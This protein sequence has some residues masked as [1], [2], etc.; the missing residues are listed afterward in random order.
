MANKLGR[1]PKDPNGDPLVPMS[2]SVTS[3]LRASFKAAAK[4]RGL[5]YVD[6]LAALVASDIGR[7]ELGP[8][9]EEGFV[10][11]DSA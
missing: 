11:R 7:L 2:F 9:I 10:L 5:S 6:Y 3:Q 8:T 1:P 4:A